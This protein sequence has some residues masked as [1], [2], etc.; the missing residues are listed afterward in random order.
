MASAMLPAPWSGTVMP[1]T[2]ITVSI[3]PAGDML[4][5]GPEA[6]L[7]PAPRMGATGKSVVVFVYEQ[8]RAVAASQASPRT[9]IDFG[10]TPGGSTEPRL[11][12]ARRVTS[13][14]FPAPTKRVSNFRST[15]GAAPVSTRNPI[16]AIALASVA[17]TRIVSSTS[18]RGPILW[19]TCGGVT[20]L[21]A[22]WIVT[23]MTL[24]YRRRP[25]ESSANPTTSNVP[26][27]AK[28]V[29]VST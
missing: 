10:K 11:R 17:R 5:P 23:V 22:D 8:L 29:R 9:T 26:V 28:T 4:G 21:A 19:D 1:L 16:Q 3:K 20:S 6:L 24:V 27:A 18:T 25:A 14:R 7:M 15:P 13:V 12:L 2:T